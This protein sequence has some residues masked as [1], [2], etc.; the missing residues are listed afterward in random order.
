M[1]VIIIIGIVGGFGLGKIIVINEIMKNL[2][3]YSV[4]LFV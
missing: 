4:V 2:E 3:G 1:K